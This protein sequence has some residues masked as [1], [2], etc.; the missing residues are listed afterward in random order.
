MEGDVHEKLVKAAVQEGRVERHDGV[1]ALVGHAGGRGDSLG[2]GDADVDHATRVCLVHGAK[3]HGTHH[4]SRNA[5]DVITFGRLSTDLVSE[6]TRPPEALGGHRETGLGMN[7]ADRVE[8][9]SDVFLGRRVT[10]ALFGD[11]VD[12]DRLVEGA[13][14]AQSGLDRRDVVAVHRADVLQ[15]QVLEHD[16]GHQRVLNA[17][18]Q[19]MQR[20][21][22]RASRRTVAQQVL[23]APRQGLLVSDRG[24][25]RVQVSRKTADR[26]RIGTTVVVDND[27]DAAVF[28]RR[29]IVQRLP[30]EAS[31][32]RAIADDTHGPGAIP[33]AM[34]LTRDTIH[35]RDRCRRVRGL[36]DVVLRLTARRVAR[37]AARATQR[38]EILTSREEL[39]HVRLV[40]S[41]K[42]DRV[43]RG[44]EHPVQADR[45]LDDAQ[46]RAK[47]PARARHVVNQ[48]RANF[49]GQFVQL[50]AFQATQLPRCA[51]ARQQVA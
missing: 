19:A 27:H 36:Y 6:D 49:R 10:A 50:L 40:A 26:R 12:E 47:V 7:R 28:R 24:A 42:N 30:G 48:E 17:R 3:S 15:A 33:L 18:L 8:A 37:Q 51:A 4:R 41:V 2:F 34:L 20:V 29:D 39:M 45:Q 35:P 13:T 14:A 1:C 9:V 46:V 11:H 25:Q 23:F 38:R 21:V 22:G 5:D 16:L 43:L 31:R 44:A 32:Q